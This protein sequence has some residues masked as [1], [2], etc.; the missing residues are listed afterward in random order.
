MDALFVP[1]RTILLV[2][3]SKELLDVLEIILKKYGYN[4]IAKESPANISNLVQQIKIDLL[5]LDVRL[6]N[7]SG[8]F[9]SKELKADPQTS[10]FPI[11]LMSSSRDHGANYQE[12]GAVDFIE[13]PFDLV[14]LV[15]KV[16]KYA[17]A[18]LFSRR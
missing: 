14:E 2:D 6:K 16:N 18:G 15:A 11:V 9:I 5:L 10:Y 3:D 13:K 12:C 17:Q 8:R 1:K 7:V 4:I